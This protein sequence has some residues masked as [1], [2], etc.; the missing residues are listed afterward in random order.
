MNT[1]T[2]KDQSSAQNLLS[3]KST[4]LAMRYEALFKGKMPWEA[5]EKMILSLYSVVDSSLWSDRSAMTTGAAFRVIQS[6]LGEHGVKND[7]TFVSAFAGQIFKDI[8]AATA[9]SSSKV[10]T[11]TEPAASQPAQTPLPETAIQQAYGKSV[12]SGE[13]RPKPIFAGNLG[14]EQ[15]EINAAIEKINGYLERLDAEIKEKLASGK[16]TSSTVV[17]YEARQMWLT[18]KLKQ[19]VELM[20]QSH[21]MKVNAA[22]RS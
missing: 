18:L 10:Q 22:N 20:S 9:E 17:K 6:A 21:L 19:L 7:D 1:A 16:F 11:T 15:A 4:V 14:I 3:G 12:E 8:E 13:P 5:I 2:S